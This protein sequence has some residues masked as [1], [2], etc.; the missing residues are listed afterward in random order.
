MKLNLDS[1]VLKHRV[2][3]DNFKIKDKRP[4]GEGVTRLS[5]KEL[6]AGSSPA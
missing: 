5:A 1:N 4:S 3:E 2:I 6:C